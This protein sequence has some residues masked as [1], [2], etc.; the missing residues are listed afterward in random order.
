MNF[1]QYYQK[2]PYTF[3]DEDGVPTTLSLTNITQRARLAERLRTHV[4]VFYDYDVLDGERPDTV[5]TK[6][7]GDPKYTWIVL[8]TNEIFSLYDWPLSSNEF[9]YYMAAKYGSLETAQ[10]ITT[11]SN[12]Y[13]TFDHTLVTYTEYVALDLEDRGAVLPARYCYNAQ[14]DPVSPESYDELTT[15]ERGDA[16]TPYIYELEQNE[17]LRRVKVISAQFLP[18]LDREIRSMF[19]S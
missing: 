9:E 14:G 7:Y 4:S 16:K 17:N 2:T 15:V 18:A 19:R 12:Y 11:E 5:A 3:I 13:F 6:I 1:F 10:A 8:L